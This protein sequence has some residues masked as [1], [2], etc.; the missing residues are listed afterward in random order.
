MA[1][2]IPPGAPVKT[3]TLSVGNEHG[4]TLIEL[5]LV[6]I[7]IM[8]LATLVPPLQIDMIESARYRQAKQ[9]IIA[10]L[11]FS[12]SKAINNQASVRFAINTEDGTMT[13]T[14][15]IRNLHIPDDVTITMNSAPSEQVSE[16]ESAI[17]FFPDGSSTGLELLFQRG[18]QNVRIHVD[19]LTGRVSN[20]EE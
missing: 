8:L 3:K 6:M 2:I 7:I 20:V 1:R 12:R 16:G 13:I 11:R 9:E 5:L 14:D 19:E 18:E 10:G 17:R 15:K 4:I